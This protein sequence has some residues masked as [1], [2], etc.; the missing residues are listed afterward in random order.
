MVVVAWMATVVVPAALLLPGT[1]AGSDQVGGARLASDAGSLVKVPGGGV[2]IDGTLVGIGTVDPTTAPHILTVDPTLSVQSAVNGGNARLDPA[3]S[4]AGLPSGARLK[5]DGVGNLPQIGTYSSG[6]NMVTALTI[7][8]GSTDADFAG[9]VTAQSFSIPTT[10]R[11]LMLPAAAFVP[12]SRG[13]LNFLDASGV[14]STSCTIRPGWA[15]PMPTPSMMRLVSERVGD[16][17]AAPLP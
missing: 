14:R 17:V 5:D 12:G 13:T 16:A 8:R 1:P 11:S 15:G 6:A 7:A 3:Q 10:A 9:N 4:V 2:L